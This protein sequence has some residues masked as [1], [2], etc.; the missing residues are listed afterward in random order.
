MGLTVVLP[1]VSL[2]E[3]MPEAEQSETT[4]QQRLINGETTNAIALLEAA[5]SAYQ[6]ANDEAGIRRTADMLWLAY[7]ALGLEQG[8]QGNTTAAL[9]SYQRQ[10]EF[11]D[12]LQDSEKLTQSYLNIGSSHLWLEHWTEARR[13]LSQG[14]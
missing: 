1:T 5:F 12:L 7:G 4:G 2:A 9:T 6:A 3:M 14:V 8:L 11:A 13:W 10:L